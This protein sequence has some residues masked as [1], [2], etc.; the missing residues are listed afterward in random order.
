MVNFCALHKIKPEITRIPM[1]GI[2]DSW[3]KVVAKQARY[4]FVIDVDRR[5]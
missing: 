4:R 3:K 5:G 1:N 2:D